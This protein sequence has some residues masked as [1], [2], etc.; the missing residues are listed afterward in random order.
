ML[1]GVED[2]GITNTNVSCSWKDETIKAYI[3]G[4][5]YTNG[6][7]ISEAGEYIIVPSDK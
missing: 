6:S 3:N 2:G 1:L 7:I 5:S 4:E